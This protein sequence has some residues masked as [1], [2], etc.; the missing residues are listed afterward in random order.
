MA[1]QKFR[2]LSDAEKALWEFHPDKAY[3]RRV[4][5]LWQAAHRLCPRPA[6]KTGIIRLRTFEENAT[7][8]KA[9]SEERIR[10]HKA[11]VKKK[12]I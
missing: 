1:V 8:T 6:I 12:T 5:I 4:A 3:Y 11:K 10:R 2:T 7:S 9:K